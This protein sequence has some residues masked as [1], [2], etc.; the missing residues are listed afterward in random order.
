MIFEFETTLGIEGAAGTLLI[1]EDIVDQLSISKIKRVVATTTFHNK[2]LELHAGVL[3]KKG[4]VYL[5]FSKAKRKDMG[6]ES[7]DTLHISMKEDTPVNIKP[8]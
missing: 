4:I 7:G 1:P 6:V 2:S 5:M 3:K 8:L